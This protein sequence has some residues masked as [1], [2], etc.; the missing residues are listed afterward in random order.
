MKKTIIYTQRVEIVESYGE[1]R[2][3]ADQNIPRFLEACG[4][5]PVPVSNALCA[6]EEYVDRIAPA[7]ILLTGG[8]SLV[9]YGGNAPERDDADKR[10]LA[11]AIE[12]NIPVY[13]FCR[14]MQSILDYF[15]CSLENVSGHVAVRHRIQGEWGSLT[16][17]SYHNQASREVKEPLRA[18]ETAE[19]GAVEA[20]EC[21]RHKIMAT[22]W[23]PE[24]EKPFAKAD[25][26]R[27]KKF[28]G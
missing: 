11:L 20:V 12:K 28:F 3:C 18:V 16:V 10:L 5:M 26:E 2:D 6:L 1:R 4:Y 17:N 8:N 13:G 25:M 14:G 19:D 7:G 9:R 22:M 24:R 21:Q 15:G 27:V 23:H